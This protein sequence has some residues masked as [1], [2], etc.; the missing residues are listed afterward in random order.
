DG[1]PDAWDEEPDTLAGYRTDSEGRGQ[2][3]GDMDGDGK[4][5][6]VDALMML[7]AAAGGAGPAP[8]PRPPKPVYLD[9][10]TFTPQNP[11]IRAGEALNWINIQKSPMVTYI[12]VSGDGFWENQTL[13]YGKKF[14]H[15]FNASGSY[16]YYCPDYG[17]AMRGTVT[18]T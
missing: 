12:L 10:Y 15:T 14:K 1:V 13:S 5:T 4:L 3:W 8:T 9:D 11:E 16:S 7:K 17:S 6:S 2:R 18:V